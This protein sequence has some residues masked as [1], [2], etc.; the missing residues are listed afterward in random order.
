VV[1]PDGTIQTIPPQQV[2]PPLPRAPVLGDQSLMSGGK[3][4]R[5]Y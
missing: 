3:L 1:G 2:M 4:R 5:G